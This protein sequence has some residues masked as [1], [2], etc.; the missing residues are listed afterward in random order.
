MRVHLLGTGAADGL[1]NPF[2]RC[3]TCDE[4]RIRGAVRARS[5]ALVNGV[6]LIDPGPDVAQ[7]IARIGRDLGETKH[8]LITQLREERRDRKISH[9]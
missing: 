7:S 5:S 4:A 2:C 1:P 3:L 8:W 6:I 9:Q